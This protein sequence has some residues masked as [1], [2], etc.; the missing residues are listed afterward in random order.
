MSYTDQDVLDAYRDSG[1]R[2]RFYAIRRIRD[3]Y[4]IW[5][6]RYWLLNAMASYCLRGN[7]FRQDLEYVRLSNWDEATLAA[8]VAKRVSKIE[9]GISD[10]EIA[11]VAGSA[12]RYALAA[13]Y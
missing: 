2:S 12:A 5:T 7:Y 10:A 13:R 8:Y 3:R 6:Q 4:R 1:H 9:P 11:D